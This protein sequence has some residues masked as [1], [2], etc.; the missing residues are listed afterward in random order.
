MRHYTTSHCNA[1]PTL[2]T[3]PFPAPL[4]PQKAAQVDADPAVAALKRVVPSAL[5]ALI[6]GSL[7]DTRNLDKV[8]GWMGVDIG[9]AAG[10]VGALWVGG[11]AADVAAAAAVA[12]DA[13]AQAQLLW[14]LP[15][16]AGEAHH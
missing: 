12:D 14:L 3:L 9:G 2:L 6:S 4:P 13:R 11:G 5:R 1:L 7:V 10:T 8:G 16:L 15:P